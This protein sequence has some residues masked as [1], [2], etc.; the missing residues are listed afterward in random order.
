MNR[1]D[2]CN[3]AI[4][5]L[6]LSACLFSL[7][8]NSGPEFGSGGYGSTPSAFVNVMD[9][10]SS[11]SSG[12]SYM[13]SWNST[14]YEGEVSITYTIQESTDSSF[15]GATSYNV[16]PNT[17][18]SISHSAPRPTLCNFRK[19]SQDVGSKN[20][21]HFVSSPPTYYCA[22]E[23]LL[24]GFKSFIHTVNTPTTY[25]YR[26][27][28]RSSRNNFSPWSNTVHVTVNPAP[29]ASVRNS[30]NRY[31]ITVAMAKNLNLRSGSSQ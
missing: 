24:V 31:E 8:C 22:A 17:S 26:V 18:S 3:A 4:C 30:F 21:S 16:S 29:A 20:F 2:P 23:R 15:N 12:T 10:P 13:I 9:P 6:C 25:Y 11:V 1:T 7:G 14:T 19:V 5:L 27:R 28:T